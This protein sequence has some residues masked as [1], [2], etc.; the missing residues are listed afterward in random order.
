MG[1]PMKRID[2]IFIAMCIV[3]AMLVLWQFSS[4]P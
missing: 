4:R 2:Y 1:D 3:A